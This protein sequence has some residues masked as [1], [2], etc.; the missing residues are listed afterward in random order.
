MGQSR[1]VT[2]VYRL[3]L[4]VAVSS[5]QSKRRISRERHFL[6]VFDTDAVRY[7]E[8]K[9]QKLNVQLGISSSVDGAKN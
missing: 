2:T 8:L 7:I 4:S 9:T 3:H 5:I 6:D 1:W